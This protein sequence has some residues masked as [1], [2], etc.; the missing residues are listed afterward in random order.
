MKPTNITAAETNQLST[1]PDVRSNISRSCHA[2]RKTNR[3]KR[4]KLPEDGSVRCSKKRRLQGNCIETRKLEVNS[5]YRTISLKQTHGRRGNSENCKT[6]DPA[7]VVR[8]VK[9]STASE[10]QKFED[11]EVHTNKKSVTQNICTNYDVARSIARKAAVT[12]TLGIVPERDSKFQ[13]SV[14]RLNRLVTVGPKRGVAAEETERSHS[15]EEESE[16]ETVITRNLTRK[17][18]G[19]K[20]TTE[21]S[22]ILLPKLPMPDDKLLRDSSSTKNVPKSNSSGTS[23][24]TSMR[25][26]VHESTNIETATQKL[27]R[28][29]KHERV[30]SRGST[31]YNLWRLKH[32][33]YTHV[34]NAPGHRKEIL[35]YCRFLQLIPMDH[36]TAEYVALRCTK[37]PNRD[38][39]CTQGV[40]HPRPTL[41]SA[42]ENALHTTKQLSIET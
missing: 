25:N 7:D 15:E 22:K 29:T 6:P 28:Y 33:G 12:A 39:M 4:F 34:S 3:S 23:S 14:K 20:R 21:Y 31:Y 42:L 40:V 9:D 32:N 11:S 35:Y 18:Y 24:G 36:R 13:Q 2:D 41:R 17:R 30:Q 27:K 10:R 1:V 8:K 37:R 5:Q 38:T 26:P 19:Y 16:T